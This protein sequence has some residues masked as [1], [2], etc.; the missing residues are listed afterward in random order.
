M[1]ELKTQLETMDSFQN[2]PTDDPHLYRVVNREGDW[3]HYFQDEIKRYIPAVNHIIALGFPKGQGLLTWLKN[4]TAEESEKV[5]N[6]AAERGAKIHEA[7]REL[8]NGQ[9]LDIAKPYQDEK[10]NSSL[11]SYGEWEAVISWVEWVKL[12]QPK[13]LTHES[14]VWSPKYLYAGTTDFVGTIELPK[15]CKVYIDDKQV[16][17][18]ESKRVSALLDWKSGGTYDDHKL[19]VAAYAGCLKQKPKGEFY[20]GIVRVGT[21]HANGGFEVKLWSREKTKYHFARFLE[22]RNQYHFITGKEEWEP[23]ITKIP[24]SLQVEVPQIKTT[25]KGKSSVRKKS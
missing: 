19:Q 1:D 9:R 22:A 7:I 21:K 20:T 17:I 16:T 14:A 4:M 11:L 15:G 25:K 23:T 3:T 2:F 12:F 24:L 13:V 6:S 10:G 5:L 8:I 18:K